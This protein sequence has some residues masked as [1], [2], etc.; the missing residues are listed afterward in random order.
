MLRPNELE[1]RRPRPAARLLHRSRGEIHALA[2]HASLRKFQRGALASAQRTR[3][4]ISTTSTPT[5]AGP[6]IWATKSPTQ[7]ALSNSSIGGNTSSTP[8]TRVGRRTPSSSPC[9]KRSSRRT[10]RSSLLPTAQSLPPGPNGKRYPT[11][12][13]SS[14]TASTPRIP[15][16]AWFFI[17]A[18]IAIRPP[19][20]LR[21]DLHRA[22]TREFLAG[23][24][25]RSGKGPHLYSAR[26]RRRLTKSPKPTSSLKI[27]PTPTCVS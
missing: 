18:A 22:P 19:A 10:F 23:C 6:T 25:A 5:A 27:S 7:I 13:L 12:M 15:S 17:S 3:I 8:A 21:R 14:T 24:L 11:G 16:A 2:R 4:S 9:A 1:H 20:S 26:H